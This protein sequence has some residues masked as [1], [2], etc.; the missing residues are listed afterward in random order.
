[1]SSLKVLI[2]TNRDSYRLVSYG[3]VVDFEETVAANS[4]ADVIAVPLPSRRAR[5]AALTRG[6]RI[7]PVAPPGSDYDL[8]LFVAMDPNWVPSLRY[9]SQLRV[10]ARRVAVYLFDS[11]LRDVEMLRR[12]R[13][14]WSLVDDVFVSFNHAV[15]TYARHLDCRVRYLP[16][17][18]DGRR[19][20]PHRNERP[21][22][23]LSVGRRLESVHKEL[24]DLARRRDLFYYYQVARAPQAID[25]SENQDLLARLCQS[26]RIQVSWP[27]EMTNPQRAE[28]NSPI[29]A[30]WFEAAASGSVVVGSR[31]WNPEFERLFPYSGFVREI[32]PAS[33]GDAERVVMESLTELDD[34]SER[35]S[36]A[37]HVRTHHTWER[38]WQEIAETCC[39]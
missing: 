38:R 9:V 17:A 14:A 34:S 6:R 28:E 15:E 1:M 3:M 30:R 33:R 8:C 7:R 10:R 36:L 23:I 16:Q 21:I 5:L 32:D 12:H 39:G 18:V 13:R 4:D 22:D 20:H 19:F 31:P 2:P 27:V 25:L 24:L 37:E 35:R 11:W 29:T 26:S